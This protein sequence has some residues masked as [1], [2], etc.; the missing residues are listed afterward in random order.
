MTGPTSSTS[1]FWDSCV[2]I[3]YLTGTPLGHHADIDLFLSE[4]MQSKRT[5][6]VSSMM[7]PEVKP[8][9]LRLQGFNNFQDLVNAY[10][11]AFTIINPNMNILM[12]AARLRD[13]SYYPEKMQKNEKKR[14]LAGMDSV[15]L[16]TCLYVR[17]VLGVQ[18]IVFHTFDDG[19][20]KNYEE[21]AVSLL[22][23]QNFCKHLSNDPDVLAVCALPR[24]RPVHPERPLL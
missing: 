20:G 17:D 16:A 10:Q 8:H 13:Y 7:V 1:L 22:N 24:Q 11:G 2:V 5:I 6:Y 9:Q 12:Q 4:A 18:D 15:H 14:V 3:R 19:K 23:Y 21:K